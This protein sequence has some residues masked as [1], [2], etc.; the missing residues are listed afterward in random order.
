MLKAFA[1]I[2]TLP[3]RAAVRGSLVRMAA[4]KASQ[5]ALAAAAALPVA[6]GYSGLVDIGAN[7]ADKAFAQDLP[8]VLQRAADAGVSAA[9][10]TGACLCSAAACLARC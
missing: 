6:P 4:S 5:G 3:G 8:E 10:V 7:L 1:G 9:I 2:L